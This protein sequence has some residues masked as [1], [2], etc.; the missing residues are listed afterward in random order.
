[1]TKTAEQQSVT[2][3]TTNGDA[4]NPATEPD[5][6][7]QKLKELREHVKDCQAIVDE[8][9]RDLKEAKEDEAA[10]VA[11][12]LRAIDRATETHPLFDQPPAA[13]AWREVPLAAAIGESLPPSV[14]TALTEAGLQTVGQFADFTSQHPLTD[15]AGIGPAKAEKVEQAFEE[16]WKR[17]NLDAQVEGAAEAGDEEE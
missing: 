8:R 9:K 17:Q 16:Y 14:L 5:P 2:E 1:M 13:E 3:S 7:W 10:A 12:L 11:E 4:V 6:A 15:V